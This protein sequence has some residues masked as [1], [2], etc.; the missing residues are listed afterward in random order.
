MDYA[1]QTQ[2]LCKTIGEQEI[3]LNVTIKVKKVWECYRCI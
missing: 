2:D 3:L 1:I